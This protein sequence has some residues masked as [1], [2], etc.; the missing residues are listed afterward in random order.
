VTQAVFV[1]L[2]DGE[3]KEDGQFTQEADPVAD[4]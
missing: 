1:V 4:L 3:I 2:P